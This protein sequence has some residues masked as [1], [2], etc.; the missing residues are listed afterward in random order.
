MNWIR[1]VWPKSERIEPVVKRLV[2]TELR[3]TLSA[4]MS[5][6]DG[7]DSK[8]RQLLNSASLILSIVTALQITTGIRQNGLLYLGL[9]VIALVL[10]VWLIVVIIR[11]MRPLFYN[12]PIP[13]KWEDIKEHY[14]G[15]DEEAALDS[16]IVTYLAALDKNDIPLNYKAKKVKQASILMVSIVLVLIIMG[17]VAL[18][19]SVL[20]PL[21]GISPLATPT[22]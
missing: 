3:S 9:L 11:G 1:R 13:P 4:Q 22:P 10:Y 14:F 8:L 6:V 12:A 5:N 19:S 16:L 18:G 20:T 15:K 2:L 21:F 7:L 17:I